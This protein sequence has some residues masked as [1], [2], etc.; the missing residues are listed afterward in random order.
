[1]QE[2]RLDELIFLE[3]SVEFVSFK[4]VLDCRG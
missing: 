1:M 4:P 3:D 2:T